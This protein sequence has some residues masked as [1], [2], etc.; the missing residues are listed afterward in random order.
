MGLFV[1]ADF[2]L[3]SREVKLPQMKRAIGI[4]FGKMLPKIFLIRQHDAE[5][6][7]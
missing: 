4:H 5:F 7:N 1:L 3:Q 2:G 6:F